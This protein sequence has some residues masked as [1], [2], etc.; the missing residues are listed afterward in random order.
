MQIGVDLGGSHVGVSII[1]EN[2]KI[3]AKKEE[4]MVMTK[5]EQT[6]EI[7]DK[8]IS[9]INGICKEVGAPICVI[10][11]IGIA[12][13]GNVK[14]GI[15]R[16]IHNL[17]I[18]EWNLSKEIEEYYGV[19]VSIR[20]DAKCAGLA[21]KK[22]GSL[23]DYKD[24]VFMC[25]G[26]GIGVAA[27]LQGDL[28]IPDRNQ[29]FEFGHMVIQKEGRECKCGNKGCFETYCSMKA[30]KIKII[31]ILKLKADISSE[32]ILRTLMVSQGLP[33]IEEYINE[34]I[35]TL[36]L[37]IGNITRILEPETISIGGSFVYFEKIL[38]TR[39]IER[40]ALHTYHFDVPKIVLATL[41]NDAGMIGASIE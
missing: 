30:F 11:K 3:I 22:Y 33:E 27:F 19:P 34:Y 28:L 38:Y 4:D 8:M 9:L 35:D 10:Q 32:Q 16:D 39:L 13:P 12:C 17:S 41:G 23:Q 1:G 29:G 24:C 36:I 37:G 2:G 14:D 26:T 21:E 31:E 15:V 18:K 6:I 7:R 5:K 25:L 40:V 20:N